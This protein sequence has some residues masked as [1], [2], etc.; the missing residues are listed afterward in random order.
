MGQPHAGMGG[1]S[2][3]GIAGAKALRWDGEQKEF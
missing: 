3:Q 2:G 1:P